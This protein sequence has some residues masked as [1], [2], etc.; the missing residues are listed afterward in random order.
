MEFPELDE[1]GYPTEAT[2]DALKDWPYED[3]GG[4]LDFAKAA[5]HWPDWAG[6]VTDEHE[7][8]VLRAEPGE[9][10][11]RFATGGWSG[12]ESIIAALKENLMV[13]AVA[14][15]LSACGGLHI[16]QYPVSNAR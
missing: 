15:K 16:F 10:Y 1:D 14:W 11:A 8:A 4:A 13:R 3:I 7:L 9:R 6:D 5:W 2:L 12:N